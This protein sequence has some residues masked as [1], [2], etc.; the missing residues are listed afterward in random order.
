MTGSCLSLQ[1]S[2]SANSGVAFSS[3]C[4]SVPAESGPATH[5]LY[6]GYRGGVSTG[7]IMSMSISTLAA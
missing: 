3:I 6:G 7:S 5:D 4:H 2:L 1:P